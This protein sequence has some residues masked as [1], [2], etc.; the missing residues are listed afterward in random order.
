M[1]VVTMY[2]PWNVTGAAKSGCAQVSFNS[3]GFWLSVSA[4][5][6]P[7]C[8]SCGEGVANDVHGSCCRCHWKAQAEVEDCWPLF[9]SYLGNWAAFREWETS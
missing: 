6:S 4:Y 5:E 2:E 8:A 3:D 1:G 7:T 9:R